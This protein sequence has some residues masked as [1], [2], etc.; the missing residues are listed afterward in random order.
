[1]LNSGDYTQMQADLLAVR[2]DRPA[3]VAFR[4]GSTVI[5][6]QTVRIARAGARGQVARNVEGSESRME[7]VVLGDTTLD[8]EVG[9]RFTE[10]GVLYQVVF[11][12]PNRSAGTMAECRAVE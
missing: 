12:R 10:G 5:D 11:V 8:V 1:M 9:D 7:V 2:D 4:R 6:A 3:S